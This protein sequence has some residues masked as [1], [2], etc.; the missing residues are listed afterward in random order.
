MGLQVITLNPIDS[1]LGTRQA[2][3]K[4]GVRELA[5]EGKSIRALYGQNY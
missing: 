2:W 4:E 5:F 3:F 1:S